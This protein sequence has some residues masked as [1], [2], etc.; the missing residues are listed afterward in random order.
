MGPEKSTDEVQ[1]QT[2]RVPPRCLYFISVGLVLFICHSL[3][4]VQRSTDKMSRFVLLWLLSA[5]KARVGHK[6][7][8][9]SPNTMVIASLFFF[10]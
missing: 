5:V 9:P 10:F 7:T 2:E 4:Q 8:H 3:S 6:H 1:F